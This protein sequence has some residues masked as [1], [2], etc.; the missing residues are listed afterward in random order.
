MRA[1]RRELNAI[2]PGYQLTFDAM[3][4]I[5]NQPI[6]EATA[7]AAPTP[8][9][10]WATTTGRPARP[11]PARS[12]RCSG[13]VYDLTDTV[14]A[15]T[16]RVP[17]SKVI[18]GVPYYGRAW[19]TPTSHLH[20][21]TLTRASTA[22]SP[23]RLH[24]AA[25]LAAAYGRRYDRVEESPWAA[26]AA[27]TCTAA[28]G[29]VTTWRQL[30]YDDA[31]SLRLRYDLVNRAGLRGAGIWALGFDGA[32]P[33]L[34]AALADKFLADRTPP[35]VGITRRASATVRRRWP[36]ADSAASSRRPAHAGVASTA[37]EIMT[38]LGVGTPPDDRRP[39]STRWLHVVPDVGPVRQWGPVDRGRSAA[40]SRRTA[41][42][43]RMSSRA[44]RSTTR[45]EPGSRAIAAS[46]PPRPALPAREAAGARGPHGR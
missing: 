6:A 13:P 2:A 26:T 43:G 32:R 35:V 5:G 21:R 42:G 17:A 30:Y 3:G 12:R 28:H 9:S 24:Q 20:A 25:D 29:C 40:G 7:R 44:D 31:A 19:S 18:L 46:R 39:R 16:A 27:R 38:V 1:V 8:C 23:S 15:F 36:P 4:S 10:S 45:V 34:R 37:A 33:E 11:S 41:A 14:K 22:A